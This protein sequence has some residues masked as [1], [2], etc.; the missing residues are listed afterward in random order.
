MLIENE[1]LEDKIRYS[2][3]YNYFSLRFCCFFSNYFTNHIPF[4]SSTPSLQQG[5]PR[6]SLPII[7]TPQSF[8]LTFGEKEECDKR[9]IIQQKINHRRLEATHRGLAATFLDIT[10]TCQVKQGLLFLHFLLNVDSTHAGGAGKSPISQVQRFGWRRM[11]DDWTRQRRFE[12]T[13]CDWPRTLMQVLSWTPATEE[14]GRIHCTPV[15]RSGAVTGVGGN[16]NG[17]YI[18]ICE[19]M[20][21]DI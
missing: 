6:I 10:S 4:L 16:S 1:L 19:G 20:C 17:V 7:Y 13:S 18:Y 12:V 21:S 3:D 15:E 8:P 2:S 5:Q 14:R 9:Y 11:S